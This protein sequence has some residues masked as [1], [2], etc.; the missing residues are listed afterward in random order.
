MHC[1]H[2]S[3]LVPWLAFSKEDEDEEHTK[4]AKIMSTVF[5]TL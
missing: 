4:S 3:S 5:C 1:L 2:V